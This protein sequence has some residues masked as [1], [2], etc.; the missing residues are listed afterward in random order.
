MKKSN[1]EQEYEELFDLDEVEKEIITE[2]EQDIKI[3]LFDCFRD[4]SEH[5]KLIKTY[6]EE[7]NEMPP[8]YDTF[9]MMVF[10]SAFPDTIFLANELNKNYTK[11]A[12]NQAEAQ[13]NFLY[14]TVTPKKR[15]YKNYRNKDDLTVVSVLAKYYKC[16]IREI[17]KN[18]PVFTKSELDEIKKELIPEENH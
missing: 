10:F 17:Q 18:A 12:N 13:Y 6:I 14:N 7:H 4:I 15:F 3:T 9:M 1:D 5:G 8:S 16:S 2:D 11:E